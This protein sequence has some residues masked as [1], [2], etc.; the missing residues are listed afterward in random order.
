M[1]T[2]ER[3]LGV[4]ATAAAFAL[5]LLAL[6]TFVRFGRTGSADAL[7]LISVRNWTGEAGPILIVAKGITAL[8][9]DVTLWVVSL[10]VAGYLLAVR[11][12]GDAM[13]LLGAAAVGALLTAS[14]KHVVHRSRPD[15]VSHL[16]E[17][18]SFSFPSGHA[19]NSTFVYGTCAV[20]AARCTNL[21]SARRYIGIV[22][23]MLVVLIG[24]SRVVLGVHWPTDVL[25]GWIGGTVWAIFVSYLA[26]RM[27]PESG[28]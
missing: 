12:L 24:S 10:T 18:T 27:R 1:T 22:T 21:V 9:N 6:I 26:S 28:F 13:H 5:G 4:L 20:I 15:V 17:V 2:V 14:I 7:I 23:A 8:G 16:A 3:C 25:T 19:A 11:R